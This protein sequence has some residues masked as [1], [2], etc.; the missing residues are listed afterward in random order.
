MSKKSTRSVSE[1]PGFGFQVFFTTE[2][3]KPR[4]YRELNEVATTP[5]GEQEHRIYKLLEDNC[6]L[7]FCMD[8][9][10]EDFSF[11]TLEHFVIF[12]LDSFG[13]CFGTIGNFGNIEDRV[14]PVGYV[15]KDGQ[16]G[17]IAS[18]LKEFLELV[19]YYPYWREII[20]YTRNEENYSVR[21]LENK[22]GMHTELYRENQLEISQTLNLEK[23]DNSIELLL[24]NLSD[25]D[26]F[27]V[28]SH[29]YKNLL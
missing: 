4:M 22:Y 10:S 24:S 2:D 23:N 11:I 18:Y 3:G 16:C 25:D 15:T 28:F 17:K 27:I 9:K 5:A 29:R 26:Q 6:N 20:E 14:H 21:D 19:N 13:N 1:V 7:R 12:G 8:E